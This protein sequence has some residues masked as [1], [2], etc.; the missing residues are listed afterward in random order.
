MRVRARRSCDNGRRPAVSTITSQRR[1]PSEHLLSR[2]HPCFV[3]EGL[4]GGDTGD[5]NGRGLLD[6][7]SGRLRD[8]LV[9]TGDG[10]LREGALD[11]AHHL[12]AGLE[13]GDCR[14][15]RLDT[16]RE[17]PAP[18]ADLRFAEPDHEAREVRQSRHQVPDV[19]AA[20][21][22]VH[23]DEHVVVPEC[24]DIGR[25]VAVLDD[26]FH[27]VAPWSAGAISGM[28]GSG[29]Q[30]WT[31]CAIR[32]MMND[33]L[34]WIT[35]GTSHGDRTA[36]SALGTCFLNMPW[37]RSAGPLRATAET[38]RDAETF[39]ARLPGGSRVRIPSSA[40]QAK[41]KRSWRSPHQGTVVSAG[42]LALRRTGE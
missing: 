12:V 20:T 5:G 19:R 17:V 29:E 35:A 14:T 22:R 8:Q 25:A 40:G 2:P 38:S 10:E 6:G 7:E 15:D 27:R 13:P 31:L 28:D 39:G 16:P 26:R 32:D 37:L 30:T 18:D 42:R 36:Q 34:P 33:T 21:G 41:S 11:D 3:A 1:W 9:R 4:E 24:Q 23:P